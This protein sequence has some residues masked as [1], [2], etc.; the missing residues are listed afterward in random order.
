ML[1]RKASFLLLLLVSTICFAD[2]LKVEKGSHIVLVGNGLGSRMLN[3]GHFETELHLRFPQNQLYIRNMCDEGNTPGFRPHPGRKNPWAFPG[4]EKFF[5]INSKK[6]VGVGHFESPD[7]W[8]TRL[9]ADIIIAFFGYNESFQG[10][11]GLENYKAELVAF[12]KHTM[13]QKY[14]GKSAPQLSFSFTYSIPG[15]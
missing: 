11:Q 12:I 4:A 2:T 15:S 5:N 7:Q 10:A 9:K 14:N 8:I 1:R 13:S 3:Y 6:N